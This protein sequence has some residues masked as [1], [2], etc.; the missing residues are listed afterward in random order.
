V[1][2]Y[3]YST[4]LTQK[5]VKRDLQSPSICFLCLSTPLIYEVLW[6][7]QKYCGLKKNISAKNQPKPTHRATHKAKTQIV[8]NFLKRH[9]KTLG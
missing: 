5:L 7:A 1:V 4:T 3:S 2:E 8:E 6:N 9:K